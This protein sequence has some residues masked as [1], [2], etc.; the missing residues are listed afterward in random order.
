LNKPFQKSLAVDLS[1][2]VHLATST[3][4]KHFPHCMAFRKQGPRSHT[5]EQ[6]DL[7]CGQRDIDQLGGVACEHHKIGELD[8]KGEMEMAA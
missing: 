1:F 7:E 3:H 4:P 6:A 2:L 8:V 5:F